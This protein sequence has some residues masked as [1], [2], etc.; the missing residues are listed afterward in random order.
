MAVDRPGD[1]GRRLSVGGRTVVAGPAASDQGQ[2]PDDPQSVT[3]LDATAVGLHAT[4]GGVLERSLLWDE[5]LSG[6]G[7]VDVASL[8][9]R[10]AQGL[11]G[12]LDL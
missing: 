8:V 10:D 12:W 1:Q 9:F 4:T 3:T 5:V 2:V 6:Y 11:W 7:V